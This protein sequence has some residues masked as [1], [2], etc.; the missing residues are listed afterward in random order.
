MC[1]YGIQMWQATCVLYAN[2]ASYMYRYMYMYTNVATE[3]VQNK[4]PGK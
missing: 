1:K 4:P 3:I 2:V